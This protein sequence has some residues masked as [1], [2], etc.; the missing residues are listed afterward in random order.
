[1]A[2]FENPLNRY[3]SLNPL[4]DF[5]QTWYAD[6]MGDRL[7]INGETFLNFTLVAP[8]GGLFQKSFKSQLLAYPLTDFIQTW[9]ADTMGD[10]LQFDGE[11]FISGA[12]WW[13]FSKIP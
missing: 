3:S 12:P 1:M 10:P 4:T 8:P 7:H 6:T 13:H 9:Y 2:F 11:F 5:I